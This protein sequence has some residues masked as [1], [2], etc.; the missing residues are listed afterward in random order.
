MSFLL[1]SM[2]LWRLI[3]RVCGC[4]L[5]VWGRTSNMRRWAGGEKG[6]HLH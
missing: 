2:L 4:E 5:Q 6:G 3:R 1:G